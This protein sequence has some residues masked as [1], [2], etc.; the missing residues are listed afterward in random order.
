MKLFYIH[1]ISKLMSPAATYLQSK[2]LKKKS[3]LIHH[4]SPHKMEHCYLQ[5]LQ[6]IHSYHLKRNENNEHIIFS[7][8][9]LT[10]LISFL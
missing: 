8:M 7:S 3:L 9:A 10:S 1:N 4:Y 6:E 5:E 2:L